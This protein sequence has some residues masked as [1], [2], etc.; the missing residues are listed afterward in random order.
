MVVKLEGPRDDKS[1]PSREAD[2]AQYRN[3]ANS[4][5]L[6]NAVGESKLKEVIND[7]F[8]CGRAEEDEDLD[9]GLDLESEDEES[10]AT[11]QPQIQPTAELPAPGVPTGKENP[12]NDIR[13]EGV[14]HS[15]INNLL[16]WLT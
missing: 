2:I 10:E 7:Y 15:Q 14:L 11:P 8:V 5:G 6:K 1:K 4:I 13:C 3:N 12:H 16:S 9:L